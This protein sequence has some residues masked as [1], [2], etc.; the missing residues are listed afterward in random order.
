MFICF[1]KKS[2]FL[3]FWL[4]QVLVTA[5]Q[6]FVVAHRLN[7][8]AV[9]GIL[10]PRPGIETMSPALEGRFVTTGSPGKSLEI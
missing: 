5:L 2:F 7:C 4:H 1:Y 8:P 9:C 10:V 3:S 6:I